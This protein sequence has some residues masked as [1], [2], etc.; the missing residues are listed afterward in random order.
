MDTLKVSATFFNYY[1][2]F[3]ILQM[4]NNNTKYNFGTDVIIIILL[5]VPHKTGGKMDLNGTLILPM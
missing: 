3:K 1:I 5:C 4:K 2:L